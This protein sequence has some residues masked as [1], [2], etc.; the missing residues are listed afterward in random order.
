MF[1]RVGRIYR[2]S[3]EAHRLRLQRRSEVA[4]ALGAAGFAAEELRAYGRQRL[5]PGVR[6]LAARKP[7]VVR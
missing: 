5:S 3:H 6:A 4:A 2:R 7:G 1:R